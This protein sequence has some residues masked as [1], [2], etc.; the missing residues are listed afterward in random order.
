[1]KSSLLTIARAE[2]RLHW[3]RRSTWLLFVLFVVLLFA[4]GGLNA[5]R[6]TRERDQQ[7][8]Y[9]QLVRAQWESQPERHPHRV[10]HYGTFAFKPPG[11]LAAIDPGV[12]S[13]AGRVL[14]LEAHRQNATNFAAA[15]ELSS[16]FRL[17][18][19]SLAFV[20]QLVL[21]L[22][23]IV[24]GHRA[25]VDEAESGR[26]RLLL[27]QGVAP[28]A[29]VI[30]KLFGLVCAVAPFVL[31]GGLAC[32]A[33]VLIDG[34]LAPAMPRLAV[35]GVAL[36][37]HTLAWLG[38]T[39]WVSARVRT[40]A[41]A[42]AVLVSL[43]VFGCIVLPR[44]SAAFASAW[45]PLPDKTSF[46]AAVTEDAR[47]HGDSHD[48]H[49]PLF[50]K[51]REETLARHGVEKAEDLPVNYR[52]IVMARGEELTAETFA[53]HFDV[54]AGLM[55]TQGRVVGH[56]AWLAPVLAVRTVSAAAAGTD[57]RAQLQFQRAAEAYRFAFVQQLNELHRDKVP[58]Q[59]NSDTKLSP[60]HW[61]GFADFELAPSSLREAL[62]DT[63]SAW[64]VLIAWAV[65]PLLALSMKEGS[66]A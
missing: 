7:A 14:Y 55:E 61:L 64:L 49:D 3:R 52:A 54:L 20:L 4:A 50:A 51:L 21:P 40:A 39:V 5:T 47:R 32:I 12:D 24:L 48:A 41:R 13:F 9:Q 8:A 2:L 31:V 28:R 6:Q 43:W 25:W 62:G 42:C 33:A 19:L 18:E 35:T 23:V 56:T 30:G 29:L 26:A 58:Y 44:A 17:G 57:L 60:D 16:A 22:I 63:A 10:A 27:G 37:L 46:A 38:L 65:V 59:Q 66:I 11:P 15:G 36:G 1:M 45:H 34:G 53:R